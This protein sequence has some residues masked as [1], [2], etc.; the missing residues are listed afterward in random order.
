MHP[1][2]FSMRARAFSTARWPTLIS[3]AVAVALLAGCAT[4]EPPKREDIQKE[5]LVPQ[6]VPAGWKAGGAEG[7]VTDNWLATF[8]DPQLDALV[9]EAIVN[10]PDLRIGAVRVEQAAQYVELARAAMRPQ[11]GVGGTGGINASGGDTSSALQGIMI[12]ASWEPDLWGRMR[13][14]RNAAQE[15]YA[16]AQADLEFARQSLAATVARAWFTATQTLQ[17]KEIAT[18][19]VESSSQL[20]SLTEKRVKVGTANDQDMATGRA[21]LRGFEYTRQQ[22]ELAHTQALRALEL[23]LGRYPGAELAARADL[24]PLPGDVPAGMPL[25][26]LERR[27]DVIAAERRVAAAFHRVGEA[28]A[29]RLPSIKLNVSGSALDSEIL[30][31]K[32]DYENPSFG[33][34]VRLVAPIYTGGALTTQVTIRTLEQREAVAQYARAALRALGDVENALATGKSLAIQA[35]LLNQV[36]TEQTKAR[37][38]MQ[39]SF[40]VGRTD[41]RAIEQA[42]MNLFAAKSDALR[43]QTEQ[44]I[45]RVNLHLALGGS[46]EHPAAQTVAQKN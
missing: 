37:D 20:L 42:Q 2:H 22:A 28:K 11:V 33:A 41:L 27:P 16:S 36:V 9:R 18:G 7:A 17:Q 8:N 14:G 3:V 25:S 39:S 34:G 26:V 5:A 12:A 19:M 40:K 6:T 46:F 38:L 1:R 10:N 21:T 13:Y 45:Q 4:K 29:A 30:E 24:T 15:T 44:L 35:D 32:Q 43:I 23:L 31:F